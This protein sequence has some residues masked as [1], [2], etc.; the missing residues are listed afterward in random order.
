M[1]RLAGF[2]VPVLGAC[3]GPT[4]ARIPCDDARTP[5]SDAV[6]LESL[7]RDSDV[8]ATPVARGF[9][10]G[11]ADVHVEVSVRGGR[12]VAFSVALSRGIV[13]ADL[14]VF[15]YEGE[16]L[17]VDDGPSRFARVRLCAADDVRVYVRARAADGA[18]DLAI[19]AGEA[20]DGV[21]G[22]SADVPAAPTRF[23]RT[24]TAAL[25]ARGFRITPLPR[26][27]GLSADVPLR[28][29][30]DAAAS[31]C[32]VALVHAEEE[33][34]IRLLDVGD[35]VLTSDRGF[36]RDLRVEACGSGDA[37]AN[38]LELRSTTSAD[39][40]VVVGRADAVAIGGESGL[41]GVR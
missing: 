10:I 12:C 14:E 16:R 27:I 41:G 26:T 3:G 8:D 22:A 4:I 30:I 25:A 18:G 20:H 35:R 38:T 36:G 24:A 2:L 19:L 29:A 7:E 34:E 32:V 6:L 15:D 1:K 37:S 33:I 21:S 13:D 23:Q 17:V 40:F 31:E 39:A 5:R 9:A 11:G 28:V